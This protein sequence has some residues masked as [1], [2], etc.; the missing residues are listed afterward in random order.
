MTT[1]HQFASGLRA[2]RIKL[3]MHQTMG[4][5]HR[6]TLRIKFPLMGAKIS[7][8]GEKNSPYWN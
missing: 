4:L 1:G 3:S 5:R 2:K 7:S 8:Y 6:K